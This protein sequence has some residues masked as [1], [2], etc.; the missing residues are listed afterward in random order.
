MIN[1]FAENLWLT[2]LLVSLVC[3]VLELTN[4]DFF[5]LCF[6]I[7]GLAGVLVSLV[8]DSLVGQIVVF[9][10]VSLLSIFFVRPIALRYFHRGGDSRASNADALI[11]RIGR[12]TESIEP[13]GYGRVQIDGDSW[14][15]RCTGEQCIETGRQVRVLG[16]DSIIITVAAVDD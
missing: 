2:W 6:A 16:I 9:S 8:T 14:K 10:I 7:G 3:L 15:A 5:V 4:G 11:G 12:V 1:Y 13:D